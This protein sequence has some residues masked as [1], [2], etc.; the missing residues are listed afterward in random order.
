MKVRWAWAVVLAPVLVLAGIELADMARQATRPQIEELKVYHLPMQTPKPAATPDF[1][2]CTD[3]AGRAAIVA[4][5]NADLPNVRLTYEFRNPRHPVTDAPYDWA[6]MR[7]RLVV[8]VDGAV[9]W[10]GRWVTDVKTLDGVQWSVVV[11]REMVDRTAP[12]LEVTHPKWTR[13]EL[14]E[15]CECDERPVWR[16]VASEPTDAAIGVVR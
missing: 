16:L 12:Q 2:Y 4:A 5:D 14:Y 8:L 6:G 15:K 3:T 10:R 13:A 1:T 9:R 7:V 11:S